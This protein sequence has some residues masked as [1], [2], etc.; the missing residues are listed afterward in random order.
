M[1]AMRTASEMRGRIAT[2]QPVAKNIK[3]PKLATKVASPTKV[4]SHQPRLKAQKKKV[5]PLNMVPPIR[6]VD[7]IIPDHFLVVNGPDLSPQVFS[8]P[9]PDRTG[10]QQ[11]Q[12]ASAQG[13]RAYHSASLASDRPRCYRFQRAGMQELLSPRGLRS[14][15]TGIRSS[16]PQMSSIII[17]HFVLM[18]VRV[19]YTV[20]LQSPRAERIATEFL[21]PAL[22]TL[23]LSVVG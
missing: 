19:L 23:N 17:V 10:L 15:M 8:R 22:A 12:I 5:L 20:H 9:Q 14:N 4:T 13:S 6:I 7:S 16:R 11:T 18:P 21:N 2:A 3:T 1:R